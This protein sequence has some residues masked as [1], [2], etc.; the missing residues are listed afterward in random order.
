M[1]ASISY[2]PFHLPYKVL[3]MGGKGT[4]ALV[5]VYVFRN[6]YILFGP[7]E[8]APGLGVVTCAVHKKKKMI[9]ITI[10]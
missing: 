1:Y 7:P 6:I 2:I 3:V 8:S 5:M 4:E 10:Y 9:K